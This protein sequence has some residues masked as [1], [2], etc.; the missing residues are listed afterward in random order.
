MGEELDNLDHDI[1]DLSV[2]GDV[3][4]DISDLSVLDDLDHDMSD[5]SVRGVK[6]SS[7]GCVYV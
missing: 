6:C 7:A 5:L 2:R 4:H 1:S 3:D